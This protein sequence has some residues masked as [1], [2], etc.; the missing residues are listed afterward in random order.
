MT[1]TRNLNRAALRSV[2]S[3]EES[4]LSC[5]NTIIR[6][7]IKMNEYFLTLH[8]PGAGASGAHRTMTIDHGPNEVLKSQYMISWGM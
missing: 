7:Q 6:V 4:Y 2:I 8:G 5:V 3:E 1:N